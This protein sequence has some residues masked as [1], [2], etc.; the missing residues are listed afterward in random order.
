MDGEVGVSKC[1][2]L[3]TEQINNKA[4]LVFASFFFFV[5]CLFRAAPAAYGGSQSRGPTGATAAGLH[6][7]HSSAGSEVHLQPSP[8]LMVMPDP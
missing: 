1:K 6:H 8:Q 5:F 3:Y 2:L 7:S 4:L